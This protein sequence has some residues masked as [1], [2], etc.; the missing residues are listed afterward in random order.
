MV[1]YDMLGKYGELGNQLFQIAVT[2]VHA[3]KNKTVAKFPKWVCGKQFRVYSNILKTP[4]DETLDGKDV[5][6]LYQETEHCYKE[7]PYVENMSL[8]GFFQSEKYFTGY[9]D[10]VRE[11][12]QPSDII[13]QELSKRYKSILDDNNSVGVHIR[14]QTRGKDDF[15]AHHKPP[16]DEY[17]KKAF[18]IFG[19]N[20]NYIIFSDNIPLVKKWFKNYEFTF[21]ENEQPFDNPFLGYVRDEK[22]PANVLELFLMS[23]C[24]NNIITSSTFGWWGAW[25]NGNKDKKV[26]S[27][28]QSM[29]Y[30]TPYN[31]FNMDD[32]LP[33]S[34]EKIK[35]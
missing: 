27:M 15:P 18:S 2:S 17:L 28:H 10:Y 30:G 3:K 25:L 20:Y 33:S 16:P 22:I 6:F 11:L 1:A 4:I 13:V 26:I 7:I 23:K 31:H 19:K 32:F 5:K 9:E 14:T 29:W 35:I 34:W 12:F 24:R 21:I 8:R